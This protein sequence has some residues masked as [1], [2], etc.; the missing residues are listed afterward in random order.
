MTDKE[1][2]LFIS[3]VSPPITGVTT[4][5][6]TILSYL[7][8][9]DCL[10][11][12]VDYARKTLVSG[13]FSLKQFFKILIKGFKILRIRRRVEH[14]YLAISSTFWGN[15][16]D[17]FFLCLIGKKK[18]SCT[19]LHLHTATFD[20][21]YSASPWWVKHLTKKMFKDVKA[22]IVVGETF[23][24]IFGNLIPSER[25]KIVKN[26][27]KPELFIPL[28]LLARDNSDIRK[29]N[30][31]YLSNLIPGKGYGILLDAYLSL[32]KNTREKAVLNFA[33]E[34]KNRKLKTDFLKRIANENNIIYHGLV[35]GNE[36]RK[37][38]WGSHILCLP[39][40]YP[41][42]AQPISILEA[43]AAGSI[44]LTTNAGGIKD[45]FKHG[46]NGYWTSTGDEA[47]LRNYLELLI[48]DIDK[49]GSFAFN[50]RQD[51]MKYTEDRFNRE[52][53]EILFPLKQ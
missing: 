50:N 22:A 19:V 6:Q 16:R 5:S 34:F 29:I 20:N 39:T 35:Q 51:A 15:M 3:A 48:S 10:V 44:V 37:L 32:P 23:A 11:Y 43:Y 36:K 13:A 1:S 38:L 53:G 27:V 46:V 4:A 25:V 17:I 41:V 14:V 7:Q 24:N 49:Y 28:S 42:E 18:R 12:V 52:I 2:I 40:S 30:I 26:C 45:I 9:K 31:L 21:Y 47:G 33:G 8:Q